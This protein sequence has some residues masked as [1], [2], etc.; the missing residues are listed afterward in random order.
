MNK[1][2]LFISSTLGLHIA[3]SAQKIQKPN[4]ILILADDLGYGDLGCYGQQKINTPH[5]DQLASQGMRFTQHYSGTTVSAPSRCSLLTGLHTGHCEIRG[6]ATASPEGQYPL[7]DSAVTLAKVLKL[8][9][10]STGCFGKW[11]LGFIEN[12]GNPLKHGF[13]NFYGYY[14]QSLAH[15]YY[16]KYLWNNDKKIMLNN[17]GSMLRDYAPDL[18]HQQALRFIHQNQDTSFFLFLPYI[19]PHAELI[20]PDDSLFRNNKNKFLPEKNFIGNDYGPDIN[21]SGYSSQLY[22]HAAF[23]AMIQRLDNYVGE[24]ISLLEMLNIDSNTIILFSSDNGPHLEA[25]ADPE[26]F[27]SNGGLRGFKRDLYEGGIRVPLIV[28]WPGNILPGTVNNHICSSWDF[29]P[30]FCDFANISTPEKTDGISFLNSLLGKE[31]RQ[32]NHLYWEFHEQGGKQA[33]R[34]NQW[35]GIKL[36][37]ANN[38]EAPIELYNIESDSAETINLANQFPDIVERINQIMINEHHLQQNFLFPFEK[39]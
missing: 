4:I 15:R 34:L 6:N 36:Q 13:D 23:A 28:S 1:L 5:I 18:I 39:K 16:P 32:H 33:V 9:G 12:T 35:K 24:I 10:Y 14:C 31:N 22:S 29:L 30:T 38:P 27:N 2:L 26:Y 21:P 17:Q 8:A 11:G 7:S 25:G 3:L 19:L 20:V 37:M